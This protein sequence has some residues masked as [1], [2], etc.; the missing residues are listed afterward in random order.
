[1]KIMKIN[2]V[3][4]F[5]LFTIFNGAP[6]PVYTGSAVAQENRISIR[7]S[8]LKIP[9]FVTLKSNRVNMRAGPGEEYPIQ[10]EYQRRGLPLKVIGEFD[11]WR[12]VTDHEGIVGWMHVRTLS[13]KRM[14]LINNRTVKVHRRDKDESPVIA[15]AEQGVIAELETCRG[16]WCKIKIEAVSGWLNRRSL[17][18]LLEGESFE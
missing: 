4:I 1:M 15:I 6:G 13:V 2:V 5:T 10:W 3:I 12:K 11:V 17:W 9:R 16:T 14:V 18:G 7:G 8:N